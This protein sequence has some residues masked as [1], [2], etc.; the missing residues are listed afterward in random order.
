MG[1]SKLDIFTEKYLRDFNPEQ[2]FVWQLRLPY[3]RFVELEKLVED[4]SDQLSSHPIAT[5]V[6]LAEWYKW[7][8]QGRG[9][10]DRKYR[11]T[12]S[13]L[14]QL[15]TDAGIDID[16]HVAVNPETRR[17][18]WLYSI[19]VLGG[20]PILQELERKNTSKL[21][22]NICLMFHGAKVDISSNIADADRAEAFR[23][24]LEPDGS[25]RAYIKEIIE[26]VSPFSSED[27]CQSDSACCR[28]ITR[29]LKAN[30]EARRDK[31]DLRW[32]IICP[33]GS[34]YL[35]RRL[36][37]WLLPEISGI[38]LSQYLMYDRVGMWNIPNPRECKWLNIGVRCYNG[39]KCIAEKKDIATYTNTGIAERGFVCWGVENA[40]MVNDVPVNPFDSVE[41]FVIDDKGNEGVAQ[42]EEVPSAMQLY[43][44]DN[45]MEWSSRT[46][47]QRET[48]VLWT[49]PWHL[50]EPIT[51]GLNTSR[52]LRSREYGE[53]TQR[54]NFTLIPDVL[55]LEAP[56]GEIRTFY[57]RQ[58]Y[59]AL[60]AKLH[61]DIFAYEDGDKVLL[62]EYNPDEDMEEETLMPV[63]F[64]DK[65][66]KVVHRD[67]DDES[68]ELE[69]MPVF[70]WK[71]GN[72]Y[73]DWTEE[74]RPPTGR[75]KVRC[76]VKGRD[77]ISEFL[78]LGGEIKRDIENKTII[79][80]GCQL[81]DDA[82]EKS[83]KPLT[84]TLQIN[85][86]LDSGY[87]VVNIWRPL[88]YKEVNI[89]DR[90][91]ERIAQDR[92]PVPAISCDRV[93]TGIFNEYGYRKYQCYP[94]LVYYSTL[95]KIE[96]W[97]RLADGKPTKATEIDPVAPDCLDVVMARKNNAEADKSD[98]LLWNYNPDSKTSIA[99]Y[100]TE[101]PKM[102]V[103]FQDMESEVNPVNVF[104]HKRGDLLPFKART[105][106]K[107]QN[108][109]ACFE[110]A[111]SY[112]TYFS[113]FYP[114]NEITKEQFS[115]DIIEPL[116]VKYNG[117]IPKEIQN[118]IYRAELELGIIIFNQDNNEI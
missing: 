31:F 25:L 41:I 77:L 16:R 35:S 101:M 13:E 34:E 114:L 72:R 110:Y 90:C 36:T 4:S 19:Y 103:L 74:N 7:R 22:R 64:S 84:P 57:N 50:A 37:L 51:E 108:R 104:C 38:G 80:P 1:K 12:S 112:K 30:E 97:S 18:S 39:K 2:P 67:D 6:Y 118:E 33:N 42:I 98:W 49:R 117:I 65:D 21:L 92:L 95:N 109:L 59:D 60:I 14:Q 44:T 85:I 10:H 48:A 78:Y 83:D 87:A 115:T 68:V 46:A 107:P 93:W 69:E 70:Q 116:L 91:R 102:T 56:D 24:S 23:K 58:G 52:R 20:L 79:Y 89:G 15:L 81:K 28:L 40:I 29:I 76:E 3:S 113:A 11:P 55:R 100:S 61:C 73:I 94:L 43:R 63:I 99:D 96:R 27:T 26:G 32:N 54:Y 5:I 111:A 17:H 86:H 8:K 47:P 66:L 106:L 53:G 71:K 9:K 88:N 45:Y 82:D 62:K 105:I 75:I